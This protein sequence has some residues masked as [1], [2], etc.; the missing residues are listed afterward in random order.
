MP[1]ARGLVLPGLG[2][3]LAVGAAGLPLGAPSPA[4]AAQEAAQDCA[5][6]KPRPHHLQRLAARFDDRGDPDPADDRLE[7]TLT[8][9]GRADP[10]AAYEVSLDARPP[11]STDAD[12]DGDGQSGRKDFCAETRDAVVRWRPRPGGDADGVSGEL[13]PGDGCARPQAA[14]GE[15]LAVTL[16]D[17]SAQTFGYTGDFQTYTVPQGVSSLQ[18]TVTGATGGSGY[19]PGGIGGGGGASA[20]VTGFLSVT[21]GQQL[22]IDVG[23]AGGNGTGTGSNGAGAGGSPNDDDA[24][25][26]GGGDGDG[27]GGGGGGGGG[28]DSGAGGGAGGE[29]CGGGGGGGAGSNYTD[30]SVTGVVVSQASLPAAT[31][32]SVVITPQ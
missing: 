10:R 7:A 12:R 2:A 14:A 25:A 22:T 32:G 20:Q 21:P 19:L 31:G 15:A 1:R 29:G 3:F 16:T 23:Q 9:C 28:F 26:G 11:L 27:T 8:L 6:G 5:A 18:L 30:P 24:A 17:P 13:L 4:R